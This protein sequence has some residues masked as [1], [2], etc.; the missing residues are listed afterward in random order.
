MAKDSEAKEPLVITAKSA[1]PNTRK[2]VVF[3]LVVALSL[4]SVIPIPGYKISVLSA[5]GVALL[6]LLFDIYNQLHDRLA[7]IEQCVAQPIPP[8]FLDYRA[9][10]DKIYND[11]ESALVESPGIDLTFLT[12]AGSYSWPFLEDTVRRLDDRFKGGKKIVV[13]FCL[14]RPEHF[15]HWS[16]TN[17]KRK[18]QATIGS[19]DAFKRH[20][21]TQIEKQQII[22]DQYQ[23][24]NIPH[25][26][27]VLINGI[28]LYLGRTEWEFPDGASPE[29]R[30]GQIEYRKF[31]KNDRFGGDKR[32]ERFKNWV[33]RYKKRGGE[34]G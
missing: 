8:A 22:I 10:E 28:V 34:Q 12:V 24:D 25:W 2:I 13:T 5:L 20:Y 29:L 11:I 27:G 1:Y 33:E 7:A 14:I 18:A 15:D 23:F 19:I 26:H 3:A 21:S 32:I 16:L 31:H 9:A 30:V 4:S 17:W 6:F